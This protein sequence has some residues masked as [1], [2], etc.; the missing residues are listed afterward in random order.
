[1]IKHP[2][3]GAI[4]AA[5]VYWIVDSMARSI[6]LSEAGFLDYL[7]STDL[8]LQ[9]GRMVSAGLLVTV[10]LIAGRAIKKRY[11][12]IKVQDSFLGLLE[13]L[14]DEYFFFSRDPEGVLT[15]VSPSVKQILGYTP[16]EMMTHYSHFLTDR[17]E[18][19]EIPRMSN[20]GLRWRNQLPFKVEIN[21]Q[22]HGVRILEVIEI[23]IRDESGR[24]FSVNGIA[25]DVTTQQLQSEKLTKQEAQ[26]R[27]IVQGANDAILSMD[28]GGSILFW[29]DAAENIFGYS[30]E[31]A[32]NAPLSIILAKS[33]PDQ[34]I[35][36]AEQLL[37]LGDDSIIGRTVALKGRTKAG[38]EFPMAFSLSWWESSDKLF[39]TAIIRDETEQIRAA[40]S[41][42]K[43]EERF[44]VV[45]E[46][47]QEAIIAIDTAGHILIFNQAA[48]K[49]FGKR[50]EEMLGD[51][52]DD[53][54]PPEYLKD[55]AEH[56]SNYFSTGR[57][58]A[59]INLTVESSGLRNDGSR[60]PIELTLSEAAMA[61]ERMV[62]GIIRD[63]SERQQHVKEM[64][65]LYE[66]T[67]SSPAAVAAFNERMIL[68]YVN[69]SFCELYG[70]EAG[71]I[72][73]EN[74]RRFQGYEDEGHMP[75]SVMEEV[76][77]NG[78]WIGEDVRRRKD[79]K[80]I[81][82]SISLNQI[83]ENSGKLIGY[84]DIS[85][86]ISEARKAQKFV[87]ERKRTLQDF[88]DSAR[89]L[90]QIISSKGKFIYVN[91]YW[92]QRMKYSDDDL[93]SMTVFDVIAPD[94]LAY[95]NEIFNRLT[96]TN[97]H[98]RL[99]TEFVSKT[100]ELIEVEGSINVRFQNDEQVSLLGIFR[101]IS[102]RNRIRKK[103]EQQ[104]ELLRRSN[105]EL[106]QFAYVASHDLQEPLRTIKNYVTLLA[107]RYRGSLD[108]NADE[109]IDFT[110]AGTSRM[111]GL[112]D[113][114]LA[115]SRI[116][117][118]GQSMEP[119]NC[120]EIL[121]HTLRRL[122]P[123]IHSSGAE[124][125]H[126]PLPMI[127]GD[128][129]QIGVLFSHL[130]ENAIKFQ[131]SDLSPVIYI[132]VERCLETD[133]WMFSFADNGLGIASEFHE[134]VFIMFQ[135]LDGSKE[136]SSTGVGLSL[137][138]KIVGRHGGH[139]WLESE[140]GVGTSFYFTLPALIG[141]DTNSS[142]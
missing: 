3:R 38:L 124:I 14:S 71:E 48:E 100:G 103:L 12:K 108:S 90:I 37:S 34:N 128:R 18:N 77:E 2:L 131:K 5:V 94:H 42:R 4:V 40:E 83:R 122:Q 132:T 50:R 54:L 30:V 49:M 133:D 118:R 62:I 134:R 95:C 78:F 6:L 69:P 74:R 139:I 82:V 92:K 80:M 81:P 1:M 21:H 45:I 99:E 9:L 53:L 104:S 84:A 10:G 136:G 109:F 91:Q 28:R 67:N 114:L 57:P 85:L 17:P 117:T 110:L 32:K 7:F 138:K 26:L 97:S 36:D 76:R 64:K 75:E 140:Q 43:S 22:R 60:F 135:K 116:T 31:E 63:I 66:V 120:E 86:D 56:I 20:A 119:V 129:Q 101:D 39:F 41:L 27:S 115:F 93:K 65:F 105:D 127:M 106:Q 47:C 24:M 96:L 98:Q 121:S 33:G 70:Y 102:R 8:E 111:Q 16:T 125:T 19:N 29:N 35:Q 79:G 72:L 59:Y 141:S 13:E 113:G 51:T 142:S 123:S 89:D 55:H 23:P 52:L 107:K 88:L 137:C 58:N 112:I 15:Y 44:R 11:R 87:E 61:E 25:H 126:T 130:I 68:T 46:A 73:G